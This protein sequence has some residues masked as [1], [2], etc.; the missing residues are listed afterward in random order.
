MVMF[1]ERIALVKNDSLNFFE[2]LRYS[3]G[4][5]SVKR[6]PVSSLKALKKDCPT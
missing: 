6:E 5:W 2:S 3:G 1:K 4:F